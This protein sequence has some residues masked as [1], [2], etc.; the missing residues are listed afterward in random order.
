MF[1]MLKIGIKIFCFIIIVYHLN[2]AKN[3]LF[4]VEIVTKVKENIL[5]QQYS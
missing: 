2:R 5:L 3:N 1:Y 4:I